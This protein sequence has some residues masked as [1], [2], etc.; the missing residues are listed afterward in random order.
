MILSPNPTPPD[1]RIGRLAAVSAVT[2]ALAAGAALPA[3][4]AATRPAKPD[5]LQT[6][7]V[8]RYGRILTD[9]TGASLYALSSERGGKLLCTGGCL[10]FWPPLLVAGGVRSLHLGAGVVGTV[11]LVP[12]G[13]HSKQV[14]YNGFP[15]YRF[16]GDR[17]AHQTHGEGIAAFGGTWTLVHASARR[18]ALTLVFPPAQPAVTSTTAANSS[19]TSSQASAQSSTTAP[20]TSVAPTT[21]SPSTS[22]TAAYNW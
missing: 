4:G 19:T 15:L 14:T 5:A 18:A 3:A 20:A 17:G 7:T 12:R 2:A 6:A 8:A 10:K 1:H 16:A 22:T 11:G 13:G 9:G 21:T